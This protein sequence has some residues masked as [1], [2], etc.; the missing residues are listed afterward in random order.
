M[1]EFENSETVVNAQS[2]NGRQKISG[3][4][5]LQNGKVAENHD[6]TNLENHLH[7]S[8]VHTTTRSEQ[9]VRP[10]D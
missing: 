5:Y 3:V 7:S 10:P 9:K 2:L 4:N 8:T 6:Q 1:K